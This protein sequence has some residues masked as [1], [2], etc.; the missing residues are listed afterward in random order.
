MLLIL[1][2]GPFKSSCRLMYWSD[3]GIEHKI[4]VANMDGNGRRLLVSTG[5]YWPNGL[6]LD[7]MNNWLYWVDAKYNKLEYYDL[8]HHTT[9]MLLQS[10]SFLPHP[11]G[12]ALVE[13]HLYWTDWDLDVVYKADRTALQHI[14]F[15]A[16]NLGQP[17]GIHAFD[18]N[19]T[20]PG[21]SF[22]SKL[23]VL[24]PSFV[25]KRTKFYV[26]KF[27]FVYFRLI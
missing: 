21:M 13:D 17:M 4:E 24:F 6:T 8:Q 15:V 2:T 12:L 7:H 11:F 20:F 1:P 3:W 16:D 22:M 10:S 18:R 25:N 14:T 19:E 23:K 26:K 9:T 27:M 5:L